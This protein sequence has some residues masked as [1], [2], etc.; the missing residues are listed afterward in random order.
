[1]KLRTIWTMYTYIFIHIQYITFILMSP[2]S[3]TVALCP[4]EGQ[5]KRNHCSKKPTTQINLEDNYLPI[6]KGNN[7]KHSE[8]NLATKT[9]QNQNVLHI[10]TKSRSEVCVYV[11]LYLCVFLSVLTLS[12][13]HQLNSTSHVCVQR[14]TVCHRQNKTEPK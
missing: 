8:S 14:Q 1:V 12:S 11:H 5:S 4:S 3:Q 9:K 6:K 2:F 7:R 13:V 10:V